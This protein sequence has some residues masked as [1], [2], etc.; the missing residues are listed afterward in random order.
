MKSATGDLCYYPMF[1]IRCTDAKSTLTRLC[2]SLIASVTEAIAADN[3]AHMSEM[4][5]E[6]QTIANTLVEEPTE[7]AELKALQEYSLA[8]VEMLSRL[9]DE[10]LSQV[11]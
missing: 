8:S 3:V 9:Y 1:S 2:T 5:E 10:Y 7:P 4:C 11:K 6:Y